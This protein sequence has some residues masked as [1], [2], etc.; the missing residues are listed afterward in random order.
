M[1]I[2]E[3]HDAGQAARLAADL[4]DAGIDRQHELVVVDAPAAAGALA[5]VRVDGQRVDG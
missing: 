5:A 1:A 3:L 2:P 4:R